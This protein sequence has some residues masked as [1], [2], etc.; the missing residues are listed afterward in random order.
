MCRL[1]KV[2]RQAQTSR[3][4]THAHTINRGA[5]PPFEKALDHGRR[6]W[7]KHLATDCVWLEV[8]VENT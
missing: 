7:W 1:T 4:I 8:S 5:F 3:I 6:E 2:F